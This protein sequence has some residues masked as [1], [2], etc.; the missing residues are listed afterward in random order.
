MIDCGHISVRNVSRS[1]K[2]KKERKKGKK[3]MANH[4]SVKSKHQPAPQ[5]EPP[6]FLGVGDFL[7]MVFGSGTPP[8]S[9]ELEG[10]PGECFGRRT[11]PD[12]SELSS[13]SAGL[14]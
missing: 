11:P 13:I 2:Y 8:D 10:D 6:D 14:C 1:E 3:I 4:D 12:S 5:F 7:E 9:S